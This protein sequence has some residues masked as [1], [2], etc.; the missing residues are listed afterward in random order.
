MRTIELWTFISSELLQEMARNKVVMLSAIYPFT[1]HH[2]SDFIII[3]LRIRIF[4][5]LFEGPICRAEVERRD[6]V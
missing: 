4:V 3:D 1:P 2:L 5:N 6:P